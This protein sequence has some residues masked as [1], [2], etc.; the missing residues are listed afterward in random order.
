MTIQ[1]APTK[2]QI[3]EAKDLAALE[4]SAAVEGFAEDLN[5]APS[6]RGVY[7]RKHFKGA[8]VK[9]FLEA[10][11]NQNSVF[12]QYSDYIAQG[13]KLSA[14]PS[15]ILRDQYATHSFEV[16]FEKPETVQVEELEVIRAKA[17]ADLKARF[18]AEAEKAIALE[19]EAAI[20]AQIEEE[21]VAVANAAAA[22]RA[23]IEKDIRA[24]RG[25]R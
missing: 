18:A 4:Y 14:L 2:Q 1:S 5:Q 24:A 21:R 12:T 3:Q 13:Y 8:I 16:F 11:G 9:V 7:P 22:Q 20:A 15:N 19:I 23:R 17:E 6:D 10:N 25:M